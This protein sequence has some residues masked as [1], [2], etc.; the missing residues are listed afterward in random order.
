MKH[1]GEGNYL[2]KARRNF[3]ISNKCWTL[4][5]EIAMEL[6]VNHSNVIELAVR[7]LYP[8]VTGKPVVP[9]IQNPKRHFD[10]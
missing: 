7:K 9:I 1:Q 8:E 2:G 10:F 4:M 6:G 5:H 3:Y